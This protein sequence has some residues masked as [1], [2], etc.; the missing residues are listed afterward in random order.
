M[1]KKSRP[2]KSK[3]T[4][5]RLA[6][7]GSCL[8]LL[9]H[10]T[11]DLVGDPQLLGVSPANFQEQLSVIQRH[12]TPLSMNELVEAHEAGDIPPQS[13]VVTFDDGYADNFEIAAPLLV[14]HRIPA[15]FFVT[16]RQ[17]HT[18]SEFWWDDLERIILQTPRLPGELSI[19]SGTTTHT[20]RITDGSNGSA[21][22]RKWHVLSSTPV[23]E[24][25]GLYL[26]LC[27]LLRCMRDTHRREIL[28]ELCNWAGVTSAG[29]PTH[30]PMSAEQL[31]TAAAENLLEIGAHTLTHPVLSTL[32]VNEQFE[33]IEGSRRALETAIL[34]P[35]NGFAYPY[36]C[37]N[38]FGEETVAMTRNA[39]FRYACANSGKPPHDAAMINSSHDAHALPRVLIRNWSGEEFHR[40][41]SG[42]FGNQLSQRVKYASLGA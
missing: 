40:R 12:Y 5:P 11:M 21:S 2:S 39:G 16:A 25:Q 17:A 26:F 14:D 7:R 30:R 29:R 41:L 22:S 10:R 33:E 38:D 27:N 3:S 35:V 28:N 19:K 20:W 23:T 15:T 6:A 42:V 13:V 31:R 9:Y 18:E 36:G 1:K 8:I 4:T 24:R 32:S 34:R 37:R